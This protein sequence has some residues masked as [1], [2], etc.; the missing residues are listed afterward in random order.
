M[1]FQ[2]RFRFALVALIGFVAG[3]LSTRGYMYLADGNSLLRPA[4]SMGPMKP[5]GAAPSAP[6]APHGDVAVKPLRETAL[7]GAPGAS[8]ARGDDAKPT[9]AAYDFRSLSGG[10][11]QANLANRFGREATDLQWAPKAALMIE[12]HFQA[13]SGLRNFPNAQMEC[14]STLCRVVIVGEQSLLAPNG[15]KNNPQVML[16]QFFGDPAFQAMF[17]DQS[18]SL[19]PD[20]ET[21]LTRLEIYFHRRVKQD[22]LLAAKVR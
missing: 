8:R 11:S 17:D 10:D 15:P 16:S 13:E 18:M 5:V 4:P 14:E 22:V 7:T 12:D 20:P 19:G 9:D 6:A 2:S 3:T 21:G 1:T